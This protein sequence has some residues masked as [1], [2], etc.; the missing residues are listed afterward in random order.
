MT[1][2]V[3]GHEAGA[4]ALQVEG[5]DLLLLQVFGGVGVV[6]RKQRHCWVAGR[7]FLPIVVLQMDSRRHL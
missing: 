4:F 3:G 7:V 6:R 1:C 5:R 2:Q